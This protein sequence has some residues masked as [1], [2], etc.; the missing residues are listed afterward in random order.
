LQEKVLVV[1][2]TNLFSHEKLPANFK[3]ARKLLV[4]CKFTGKHTCGFFNWFFCRKNCCDFFFCKKICCEYFSQ[5]K[6][7]EISC[8]FW[9][10]L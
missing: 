2:F 3:Y 4:K 6:L 5:K 9:N 1:I 7:Q 10:S 8:E